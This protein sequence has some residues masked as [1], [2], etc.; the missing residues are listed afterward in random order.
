ML[1]DISPDW[2]FKYTDKDIKGEWTFNTNI[3]NVLYQLDGKSTLF[4]ISQKLK[5]NDEAIKKIISYLYK[6][7]LIELVNNENSSNGDTLNS[8]FFD[9]IEDEFTNVVGPVAAL[10]IDETLDDMG[11]D[12]ASFPKERIPELIQNL[13]LECDDSP[14]KKYF[15]KMMMEKIMEEDLWYSA[16]D[17]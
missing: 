6:L 13:V 16:Q 4:D 5:L 7:K 8:N 1:S 11:F 12:R 15:I 17:N 2:I 3:L 14:E 9:F 10:M